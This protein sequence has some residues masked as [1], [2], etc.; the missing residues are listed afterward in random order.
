MRIELG[1]V[2]VD[3]DARTLARGEERL[4]LS[5]K[6]FE[7]LELLLAARPR[8]VAKQEIYDK[9]W[10][11]TFVVDANLPVLIREIR[12][13]IGDTN[14]SVIRTVHR[15]GYALGEQSGSAL[16]HALN[17]GKRHFPL[18][19][20]ENI[21]GRDP[22]AHV[23]LRATAVSRRHAIITVNGDTAT[24]TDLDS[25]N[26][27]FLEGE[28]ISGAVALN[29]GAAIRFGSVETTYRCALADSA[30]ETLTSSLRDS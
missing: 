11:D 15:F 2:V 24:V 5:P 23:T 22:A 17:A 8:A 21:V 12:S 16:V 30:T 9:L 26:G 14:H 6:A 29:D 28:K 13:A 3:T 10:P 27:T 7:L 18:Q 4:H 19:Q 1:P 25:K 20:G